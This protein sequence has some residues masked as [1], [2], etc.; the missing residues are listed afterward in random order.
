MRIMSRICG[1]VLLATSVAGCTLP[2]ANSEDQLD[3]VGNR[4]PIRV[5]PQVAT[6]VVPVGADGSLQARDGDR[7]RAFADFW[8]Q[9]G[10]GLLGVSSEGP[11]APEV[12]LRDVRTILTAANVTESSMRVSSAPANDAG[13]GVSVSLT[14]MTDVAV[15]AS[16]EG[17]WTQ[18]IGEEPRNLPYQNYA[19][20]TQQNLAAILEDPRDLVQPRQQDPSDAMRRGVVL[21]KYRKGEPTATQTNSSN[22]SGEVSNVAKE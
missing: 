17:N 18:D 8:K 1:L 14:F 2:L 4:F 16:C 19:C 21:D 20:S 15:A 9:R 6:L 7:V 12:A 11:V 13:R 22:E 10:Y 3:Q 5:E